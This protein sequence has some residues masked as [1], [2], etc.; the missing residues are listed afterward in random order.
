[1]FFSWIQVMEKKAAVII[2]CQKE[3]IAESVPTFFLLFFGFRQ[4]GGRFFFKTLIHPGKVYLITNAVLHQCPV[5]CSHLV[6]PQVKKW[7][8]RLPL[9]GSRPLF[10][11]KREG[12]LVFILS[13]NWQLLDKSTLVWHTYTPPNDQI[14]Q[15]W[16]LSYYA[17]LFRMQGVG[18]KITCHIELWTL[19]RDSSFHSLLE[20]L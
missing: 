11:I 3:M 10:S 16:K 1:M 12:V 6:A 20:S 13:L 9:G 5:S 17:F 4:K 14:F 15:G 2:A 18:K 8:R 7:S 19:Y